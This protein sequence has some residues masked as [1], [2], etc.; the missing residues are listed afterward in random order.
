[1]ALES[2]NNEGLLGG[3]GVGEDDF[4]ALD[5]MG[6]TGQS[7]YGMNT[8]NMNSS[9]PSSSSFGSNTGSSAPPASAGGGGTA[10]GDG[11][12]NGFSGVSGSLFDRIRARTE[13]Q[14][15]SISSSQQPQ[16]QQAATQEAAQSSSQQSAFVSQQQQPSSGEPTMEL[17]R[18]GSDPY[19][20]VTVNAFIDNAVNNGA[21]T[22]GAQNNN[23]ETTYSFSASAPGED[24]SQAAAGAGLRVPQYGASRDDPY[25]AAS[26]NQNAQQYPTSI[27]EKAVDTMKS[28][29]DAGLNGAQTI[30]AMAQAKLGSDGV[31]AT[32]RSYNNNFLLREDSMENGMGGPPT[33]GT[34]NQQQQKQ[35]PPPPISTS[36]LDPETAAAG[37][38]YSM[39]KYGKTFCEDVFAFV[40]QLPPAGKGAV[41]VVLLWVLYVLFG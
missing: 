1:M 35:P 24:F 11:R 28:L 41:G 3:G 38:G 40:M 34:M 17:E 19:N 18:N 20:T 5:S 25:Y 6:Y 7:Q 2:N 27:Q 12:D 26:N 8:V 33:T 16:Q 37:Q 4:A 9:T 39:L 21:G 23:N 30:S 29:W 13:Q 15:Q 14:K 22:S 10:V 31:D 32:P 36:G